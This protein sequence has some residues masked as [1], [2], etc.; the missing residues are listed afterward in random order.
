MKF[1]TARSSQ[2]WNNIKQTGD[3]EG[4]CK[5]FGKTFLPPSLSTHSLEAT[6]TTFTQQAL[7]QALEYLKVAQKSTKIIQMPETI[8]KI[9]VITMVLEK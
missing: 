6:Y 9:S 4:P 1:W 8:T 3:R 5:W 2:Q 7:Q